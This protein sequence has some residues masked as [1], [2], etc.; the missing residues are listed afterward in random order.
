MAWYILNMKMKLLA[1]FPFAVLALGVFATPASA[2]DDRDDHRYHDRDGDHARDGHRHVY[3]SNHRYYE[4][5]HYW[6]HPRWNFGFGVS[7]WPYYYDAYGPEYAYS[8][9]VY[10]ERPIYVSRSLE[11][12]VQRALAH[13]GYYGGPV[14]GDIGPQTRAAIRAYQ[15][16]RGL[17]VSG[18]VDG[19]LLHSLK[20]L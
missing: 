19:S 10:A 17:P 11:I 1:F 4:G 3:Y 20:L 12:D 14:D 8:R 7:T 9:P 16:D 13:R 6:F 5:S 2:R 15:V 18:R